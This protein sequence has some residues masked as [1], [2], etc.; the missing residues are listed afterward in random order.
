LEELRSQE[1]TMKQRLQED[2]IRAAF[3]HGSEVVMP[4]EIETMSPLEIMA[5][6]MRARYVAGDHLGALMAAQAAAP[7]V[8]P[9]LNASDVTVRHTTASRSDVEISDEIEAIRSRIERAKVATL[10]PLIEARA[11]APETQH[12]AL[13]PPTAEMPHQQTPDIPMPTEADIASDAA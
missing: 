6:V 11:E 4:P 5:K 1:H 12:A 3:R 8:H 9:R 2:A 10:P 13:R 7:Y